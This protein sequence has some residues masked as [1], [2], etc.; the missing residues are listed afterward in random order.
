MAKR[1]SAKR[2]QI[3]TGTDARYVKRAPGGHFK[4]SDDVRRS[5]AAD[6]ARKAKRT[7]ASGFGDQGD[8]PKSSRSGKR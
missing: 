3:N 7:V 4:E 2:E 8:R 5:Q 1:A 6:K